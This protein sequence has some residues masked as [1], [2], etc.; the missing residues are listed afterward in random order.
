M[1]D[2]SRAIANIGIKPINM[3]MGNLDTLLSSEIASA[4]L[5]AGKPLYS[6]YKTGF[7][8]GDYQELLNYVNPNIKLIADGGDTKLY[9]SDA[10]LYSI[11]QDESDDSVTLYMVSLNK[12][13]TSRLESAATKYLS[14]NKKNTIFT[15]MSGM[16]DLYLSPLGTLSSPLVRDNYTDEVLG[17]FD[18]LTRDLKALNPFGRLAI[19]NGPPGTGKTYLVRGIINEL[20]DSTVVLIP[21]RMIAEI[22]GPSLIST[23]IDHRKRNDSPII[24][25]IE[26]ADQ[27]LAPR[28]VGDISSISAL[29]NHTDGILGSLLN[30]RIVAT[31]NQE[32]MEFDAALTRAGRLS[33]HIEVNT[34]DADKATDVYRRLTG[35]N[36][37][38]YNEQRDLANVYADAKIDSSGSAAEFENDPNFDPDPG[39]KLRKTKHRMGF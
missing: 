19:V 21:P 30:L 29:L 24:L 26:D 23:F 37:F 9:I 14:K 33:K 25:V 5:E 12:D 2:W 8:D 18:F 36:E 28:T 27:C 3:D 32:S 38:R 22:D 17:G 39:F 31:T 6:R 10:A 11:E 4:A 20:D 13:D 15:L 7:F 35:D 1:F 16:G 34:L